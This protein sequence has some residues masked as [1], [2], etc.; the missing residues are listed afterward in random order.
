TIIVMTSNAGSERSENLLGFEKSIADASKEKALKALRE[1]LRPEFIARVDEI[2]VFNPLSTDSLAKIAEIMLNEL[3]D[4]LKDRNITFS[5]DKSVA[6]N[7]AL[8]CDG[9]KTG[10]RELR[11]IIRREIET[12]VVDMII[13]NSSLS[14]IVAETSNNKIT[15]KVGK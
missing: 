5:F 11:N 6:E 7:I 10:A 15:L 2:V 12:P 3:A 1:F 8:Q 13:V 4:A 9:T 14:I